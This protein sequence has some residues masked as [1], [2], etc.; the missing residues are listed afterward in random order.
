MNADPRLFSDA[1]HIPQL[2]Y[3]DAIEL[4]HSGAQVIHPKTIKPLQNKGIPLYVKPFLA[5]DHA[6]TLICGRI[7]T[8]IGVPILILKQRQVLISIRPKDFSF[9]L[10]ES[11]PEIFSVFNQYRQ[12][13]NLIQS[14]AVNLSLLCRRFALSRSGWSIRCRQAL[15]SVYNKG[16][17]LLT[18]R[19][20]DDAS[21]RRFAGAE[22]VYLVQKTRR[23]MRV[24][25]L[26]GLSGVSAVVAK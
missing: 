1:V 22:G 19:G 16:M 4:A 11:L 15:G 21:Y 12:K 8:P 13:I 17:E 18:V 2:T 10:D 6:G 26:A 25:R 3:L 14:S 7:D 9:V 20:Y 5:P 23:T 24:V